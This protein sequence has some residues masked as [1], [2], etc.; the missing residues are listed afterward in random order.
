MEIAIDDHYATQEESEPLTVAQMKHLHELKMYTLSKVVVPALAGECVTS[1]FVANKVRLFQFIQLILSQDQDHRLIGIDEAGTFDVNLLC[2]IVKQIGVALGNE[3]LYSSKCTVNESLVEM[4]FTCGRSVL[5]FPSDL[6]EPESIGRLVHWACPSTRSTDST[7]SDYIW[8]T[9]G[10]IRSLGEMISSIRNGQ[11]HKLRQDLLDDG[12]NANESFSMDHPIWIPLGG[13]AGD[14]EHARH[15][16]ELEERVFPKPVMQQP[17]FLKANK[18]VTG[19]TQHRTGT[20]HAS[21]HLERRVVD[22]STQKLVSFDDWTP[23]ATLCSAICQF[24]EEIQLVT[25]PRES[26]RSSSIQSEKEGENKTQKNS[27]ASDVTAC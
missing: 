19:R 6:V 2:A 23:S 24:Q 1:T 3:V 5:V 8:Y 4:M 18:Y 14:K 17:K 11:L 26:L 10:W 15:L 27:G 20:I 16:N 9:C 25:P 12:P 22:E 13:S 7:H 21:K